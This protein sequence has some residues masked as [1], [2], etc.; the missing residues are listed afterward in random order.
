MLKIFMCFF[1]SL[2]ADCCDICGATGWKETLVTCSICK[3]NRE[4]A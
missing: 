3:E 2:Q 1:Y 4:H